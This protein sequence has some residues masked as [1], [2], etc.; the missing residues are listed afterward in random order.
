MLYAQLRGFR[1]AFEA[2]PAAREDLTF[3]YSFVVFGVVALGAG[4]LVALLE[5]SLAVLL[6]TVGGMLAYWLIFGLLLERR[7]RRRGAEYDWRWPRVG[8]RASPERPPTARR[9]A[10]R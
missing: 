8:P 10:R 3:I 4:V 7:R 6:A 1:W 5:R 9:R 2:N